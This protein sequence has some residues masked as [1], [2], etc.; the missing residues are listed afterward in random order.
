MLTNKRGEDMSDNEVKNRQEE[1]PL[2]ECEN[3]C[4]GKW[5]WLWI[6][7]VLIAVVIIAKNIKKGKEDKTPLDAKSSSAVVT[8]SVSATVVQ[9]NLPKLIEL[10]AD[11]CVPCRMMAPI[12]EDLKKEYAGIFDVSF[13]DVW[14]NPYA[15]EQYRIRVI[16]T[17]IFLDADGKELFRHEGFFAKEDILK[18][19][20]KFGINVS[21]KKVE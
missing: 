16:P 4:T 1:K 10:G 12:L 15:G 14:K 20:E 5:K 19:W 8:D 13:I 7:I 17:Q 21:K 6:I 9:K 3:C 11:K 2:C 18:T